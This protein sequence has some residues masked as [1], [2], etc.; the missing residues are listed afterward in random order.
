MVVKENHVRE[1]QL[2]HKIPKCFKKNNFGQLGQKVQH[3]L[4]IKPLERLKNM[5]KI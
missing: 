5:Q 3:V 1:V 4:K 2:S